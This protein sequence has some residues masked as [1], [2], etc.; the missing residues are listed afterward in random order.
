MFAREEARWILLSYG[1][2]LE[3]EGARGGGGSYGARGGN[4]HSTRRT[5]L[6]APGS[7]PHCAECVPLQPL[8]FS[9]SPGEQLRCFQ[10]NTRQGGIFSE[11]QWFCGGENKIDATDTY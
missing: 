8:S 6:L 3:E 5:A 2:V 1:Y 10:K 11:E 4:G 7:V 9:C